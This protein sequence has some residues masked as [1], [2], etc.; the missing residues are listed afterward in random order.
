MG[1]EFITLNQQ[2]ASLYMN[3]YK[4]L[5]SK[6][7]ELQTALQL[8][9]SNIKEE[10][11]H[12]IKNGVYNTVSVPKKLDYLTL[13]TNQVIEYVNKIFLLDKEDTITVREK[14]RLDFEEFEQLAKE[15][16]MEDISKDIADTVAEFKLRGSS[17]DESDIV[18]KNIE[19]ATTDKYSINLNGQMFL[20]K[21]TKN[22][23]IR[24]S[25]L[26][27]LPKEFLCGY[28]IVAFKYKGTEI[29]VTNW[30][31][32]LVK[33]CTLILSDYASEFTEMMQ[34]AENLGIRKTIFKP[35]SEGI[36]D[37]YKTVNDEWQVNKKLSAKDTCDILYLMQK[38]I[39]I[40]DIFCLIKSRKVNKNTSVVD[41]NGYDVIT[42]VDGLEKRKIKGFEYNDIKYPV[43]TSFGLY[44]EMCNLLASK[45]EDIFSAVIKKDECNGTRF[46]HFATASEIKNMPNAKDYEV[47]GKTKYYLYKK[48]IPKMMGERL[49]MLL[50]ACNIDQKEFKIFCESAK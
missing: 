12:D 38:E 14:S 15:L 33:C 4:Q 43:D 39:G 25:S 26:V 40:S 1:T 6:V 35:I 20:N 31:N 34:N 16:N 27:G 37:R 2:I 23:Y 3:S 30:Q 47:I 22:D 18:D 29:I 13:L 8:I 42:L 24:L 19:S 7:A 46:K 49:L 21:D 9:L 41:F 32:Y 10:I 50:N 48:L 45:Y 28:N 17:K 36:D 11:E 5:D 44:K